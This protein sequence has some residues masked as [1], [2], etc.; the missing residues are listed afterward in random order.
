[1]SS[2]TTTTDHEQIRQWVEENNGRPACVKGT[3]QGND[4]GM[5]RIDFDEQEESLS[6]ITWER[7]FDAFE[8]NKLALLHAKDSRFNKLVN[9]E[10]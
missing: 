9:R 8:R 2:A 7:W 3:G 6:P 1:M 5:I 10:S 4:V